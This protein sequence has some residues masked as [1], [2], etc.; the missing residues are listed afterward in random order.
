M[1]THP[2]QLL[3]Y[4]ADGNVIATLDS[5]PSSSALRS[6]RYRE[7][8]PDRVRA[9]HKRYY[10]AHREERQA[11]RRAYYRRVE[12]SKLSEYRRRKTR[13]LREEM[14]AAYG[15]KCACCGET[16]PIF[17]T[18]EHV[19]GGGSAHRRA[20]G[21]P[22]ADLKRRGWPKD[23]YTVLC[24]NCNWASGHGGCPHRSVAEAV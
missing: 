23:G 20:V 5:L 17:L 4:D 9:T 13:E 7:R 10:E 19:N 3:A 12:P 1:A 11:D 24:F 14:I 8:H 22:Y 2:G 6:R 16:A 18:L 21:N 15:G